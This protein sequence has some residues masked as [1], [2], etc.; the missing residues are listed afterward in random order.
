[1][2]DTRERSLD[3]GGSVPR[4]EGTIARNYGRDGTRYGE[5]RGYPLWAWMTQP[6][7]WRICVLRRHTLQV[8]ARAIG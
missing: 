7:S 2:T 3:P 8:Q 5:G 1:M 6:N 4:I